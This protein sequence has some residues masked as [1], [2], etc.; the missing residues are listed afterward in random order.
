MRVKSITEAYYL[1]KK[2]LEQ[3]SG[4]VVRVVPQNYGRHRLIHAR[5][6][7]R[8]VS[9]PVK[10]YLI[11]Q[12]KPFESFEKYFGFPSKAFTVNKS[13]L[14]YCNKIDV[15]RLVFIDENG[16]VY[17]IDPRVALHIAYEKAWIRKTKKTGEVVV[18]IPITILLKI[19]YKELDK[20]ITSFT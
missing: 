18:H 2:I 4:I 11:F 10:F 3:R 17:M 13:I 12:R 1:F 9:R 5:L 8:G 16:N 7:Y 20:K 6:W 14:E 15:D 19:E